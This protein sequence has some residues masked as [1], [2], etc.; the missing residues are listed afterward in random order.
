M[1]NLSACGTI[2]HPERRGQSGGQLDPAI[3]VLDA[4]GLLMFF[5]PG[6]V[7]FAVDFTT[8]AIYL[9]RG[10]A[11]VDHENTAPPSNDINETQQNALPKKAQFSKVD[12]HLQPSSMTVIPLTPDEIHQLSH[13]GVV[14]TSALQEIVTGKLSTDRRWDNLDW[15][16]LEW[17]K[18]DIKVTKID[19]LKHLSTWFHYFENKQ[20]ALQNV[21][22]TTTH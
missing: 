12:D 13:H 10:H 8:G 4:V 1:G 15:K 19:S 22:S 16:G 20:F 2:L 6:V 14:K 17:K 11:S 5:V 21:N 9:P 7:A 3:V 18:D